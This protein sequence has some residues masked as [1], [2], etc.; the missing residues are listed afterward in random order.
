MDG[1]QASLEHALE[2]S[3][4]LRGLAVIQSTASTLEFPIQWVWGDLRTSSSDK[5]LGDA[6]GTC[7]GTLP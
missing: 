7:L 6:N 2:H 3:V 5:F 1:L 4:L